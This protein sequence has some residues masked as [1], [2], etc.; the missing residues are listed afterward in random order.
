MLQIVYYIK[1]M[2]LFIGYD[3]EISLEE[4]TQQQQGNG[5]YIAIRKTVDRESD[6]LLD[7]CQ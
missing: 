1:K 3:L 5:E 6:N 7:F 2:F 4:F